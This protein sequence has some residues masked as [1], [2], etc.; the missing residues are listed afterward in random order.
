[1]TLKMMMALYLFSRARKPSTMVTIVGASKQESKRW[2]G[3]SMR[4]KSLT[5][6]LDI[7]IG[8]AAR[9]NNGIIMLHCA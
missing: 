4:G 7:I 3:R 5:G 6:G 2:N 1:M 9:V 8:P